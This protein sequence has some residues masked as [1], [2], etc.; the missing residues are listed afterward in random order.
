LHA[1]RDAE[2]PFVADEDG[3]VQNVQQPANQEVQG[4]AVELE[5]GPALLVELALI[6]H[7]NVPDRPQRLYAGLGTPGEQAD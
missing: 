4:P 3:F 5:R 2:V 6:I 1:H 7:P